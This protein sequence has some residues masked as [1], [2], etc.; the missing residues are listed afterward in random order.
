[1][2]L[3]DT[4]AKVQLNL[5]SQILAL[6]DAAGSS[7]GYGEDERGPSGE[8]DTSLVVASERKP[9]LRAIITR[10]RNGTKTNERRFVLLDS[11]WP[12]IE[13]GNT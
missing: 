9:W 12:C 5:I 13:E 11:V 3:Q 4:L 1:M 8:G 6:P 2:E 7:P 10:E